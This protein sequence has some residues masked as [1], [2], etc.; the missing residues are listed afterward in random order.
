MKIKI[1][2]AGELD[3]SLISQWKIIQAKNINLRSPYYCPEYTQ[4]VD[5]SLREKYLPKNRL[6]AHVEVAVIESAASHKI[7]GFFP[8][9]R[10][11]WGQI[12]P[13]GR[14]LTDYQGIVCAD[15]FDELTPAQLLC[16][17]Q[18]RY[19]S[20]NHLPLTAAIFS[21][22]IKIRHESPVLQTDG[23]Y[24]MYLERLKIAQNTSNPGIHRQVRKFSNRIVR[25]FGPLRF[26]MHEQ[27]HAVLQKLIQL[28]IAQ[29][30]I[31]ASENV[32]TAFEIP[33]INHF[34]HSLFER[35]E[36]TESKTS[37]K[38]ALS[39]LY[40][41]DTLLAILLSLRHA[42]TQ[43]CW[44]TAY[45]RN[46]ASYSCGTVLLKFLT[47]KFAADGIGLIDLGRG[48]VPYKMRICT[49]VIPLG[50]GAC[51]TPP[52]LANGVVAAKLAVRSVRH[53]F[54]DFSS[55]NRKT[56]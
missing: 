14:D 4:I 22:A 35:T 24:E 46:F 53:R 30:K 12:F 33:W 45:D 40:A 3:E 55:L 50:E 36:K 1:I 51:S 8:F 41:G 38:C 11:Q 20:F 2:H 27:S 39:T 26:E 9:Q 23:G 43:H 6:G 52:V 15:N 16:K 19:F 32:I 17:I 29:W 10:G 44:F 25:E 28:K 5:V 56:E 42:E 31:G 34:I 54:K 13:V 47:E 21:S 48:A 49:G 37:F 7:I 18:A